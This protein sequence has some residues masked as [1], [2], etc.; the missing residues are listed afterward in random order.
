LARLNT[1]VDDG[2]EH[3]ASLE[4]SAELTRRDDDDDDIRDEEDDD[5]DDDDGVSLSLLS[6]VSNAC[7]LV[8]CRTVALATRDGR[9]KLV[10]VFVCE[11]SNARS[12]DTCFIIS[13][14]CGQNH[15]SMR[16]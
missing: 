3:G 11:H 5:D 8:N 2:D 4:E 12:T 6:L 7:L 15:G 13:L 16:R 1:G 14:H 10:V 9:L